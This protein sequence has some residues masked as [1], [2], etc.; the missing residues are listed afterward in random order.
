MSI[1]SPERPRGPGREIIA[2]RQL[3]EEWIPGL[4]LARFQ[5]TREAYHAF[6][7]WLFGKS[8][9][10]TE[11]TSGAFEMEV[12]R[13]TLPRFDVFQLVL[14]YVGRSPMHQAKFPPKEVS[15]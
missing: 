8:G 7:E 12:F 11:I 15:Q 6:A 14:A 9:G 4:G 5:T 1:P 2:A 3:I 13:R 10:Y